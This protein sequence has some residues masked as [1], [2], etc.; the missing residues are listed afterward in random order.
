MWQTSKRA[1]RGGGDMRQTSRALTKPYEQE[2][3]GHATN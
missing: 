3:R 1:Q 2:G